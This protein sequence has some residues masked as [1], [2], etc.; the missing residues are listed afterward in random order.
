MNN[1][2]LNLTVIGDRN[3]KPIIYPDGVISRWISIEVDGCIF[4]VDGKVVVMYDNYEDVK[5]QLKM[6]RMSVKRD[7][8]IEIFINPAQL[9]RDQIERNKQWFEMM[10]RRNEKAEELKPKRNWIVS[11]FKGD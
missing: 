9:E 10:N 1:D 7:E 6:I 11:F 4:R 3:Q 8:A 5:A 2:K